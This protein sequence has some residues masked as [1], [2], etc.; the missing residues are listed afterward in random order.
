MD[1]AGADGGSAN[2]DF[3][4]ADSGDGMSGGVGD[5]KDGRGMGDFRED[6]VFETSPRVVVRDH[7]RAA[8]LAGQAAECRGK[9]RSSGQRGR[10]PQQ[11]L[12]A[13]LAQMV[14]TRSRAMGG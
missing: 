6:V 9:G 3:S 4:H 1:G 5:F 7:V 8:A 10:R 13:W 2:G 12:A 14:G 11:I